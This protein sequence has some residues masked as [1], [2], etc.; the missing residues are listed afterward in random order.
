MAHSSRPQRAR[1]GTR[2]LGIAVAAGLAASTVACAAGT[3]SSPGGDTALSFWHYY[4]DAESSNGKALQAFIDNFEAENGVTVDIRF[5]PF[6]DFNR[7]LLQSAAAGDLPDV[8][9]INAFD[10]AAM[11]DAGVTLDLSD[12][13]EEWGE[14]D[15]YF[16]T[17]WETTQVDGATYGIPHVADAYAV[18]YN[19]ALFEAA[20][21]TPPATW[22]EME[23]TAAELA[24]EGRTGLAVSGIEGAEGATG[25][26]IR[27][28][29]EGGT[30]EDFDS[31]A[32]ATALDSF[33]TMVDSGALSPGFLTWIEDDAMNQFATEQSAMMI[34][35]A[36]YINVLHNDYPDLAWD[37]ALLPEGSASRLTFLSAE[38]LSIGAASENADAAWDLITFM[39]RPDELAV[40]LPARNKLAARNDVPD[41]SGD[42]VRA[43]FNEQLANAWAPEGRLAA[44][45]NEV[46]TA[47]QQALQAKISGTSTAD[48]LATAQAAIDEA[49]AN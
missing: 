14:Q 7:T 13:V 49:L 2:M 9:L 18:Y 25:L 3:D 35:S 28:L 44:V 32:G 19:T 1:F 41:E 27:V 30:L 39:Q 12:R 6:A 29:A 20:G 15:A 33:Q 16:P 34:N 47:V 4:G 31:E 11:A 38:N 24:T 23:T 10:T 42:P 46:F 45:S 36:S 40:Y 26:V 8:A 22:D 37:V 17:S 5:I 43:T 48:A 21:L